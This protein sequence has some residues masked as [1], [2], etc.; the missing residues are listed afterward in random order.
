MKSET[1]IEATEPA[2]VCMGIRGLARL[3]LTL[4]ELMQRRGLRGLLILGASAYPVLA[5]TARVPT[6]AVRRSDDGDSAATSDSQTRLPR[7]VF[8]SHN[9]RGYSA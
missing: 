2:L 4:V 6:L 7:L 9:P 1:R 5:V 8:A 3:V